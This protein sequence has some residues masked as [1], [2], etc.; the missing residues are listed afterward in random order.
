[1]NTIL[2]GVYSLLGSHRVKEFQS[3]LNS[4]AYFPPVNFAGVIDGPIIM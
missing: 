1:M 4:Q 3:M 2:V